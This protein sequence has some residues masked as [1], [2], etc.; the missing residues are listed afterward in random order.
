[1]QASIHSARFRLEPPLRTARGTIYERQ[2]CFVSLRDDAGLRGLGEAAPLPGWSDADI[3]TVHTELH[4]WAQQPT[5][6]IADLSASARHA[7]STARLDIKAQ[8]EG[9]LLAEALSPKWHS[10]IPVSH[11][12]RDVPTAQAAI[13]QG[14]QCLKLKVGDKPPAEDHACI[15]QI[16]RA[17]GPEIV[18]RVDANRGWS[19][20]TAVQMIPRLT[21]LGVTLIEEPIHDSLQMGALRELGMSIAAD[22]SVRSL[23]DL[24]EII[25]TRRAD[26]VVFKP[27]LI[28]DLTECMTMFNTATDAGLNIMLTTTIDALVARRTVLHLAATIPTDLLLPCGV[29]TGS[30]LADDLG[31]DPPAQDG[32]IELPGGTG[33]GLSHLELPWVDQS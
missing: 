25:R 15:A 32:F 30:W 20:D 9:K 23:S 7:V 13:A 27:M 14:A 31:A 16:R 24:E 11:L 5:A 26:A 18:I 6:P 28:G 2:S 21:S 3:K 4:H 19:M 8:Q 22:E 33:L 17:V 29:M 1:M 12:V 10:R